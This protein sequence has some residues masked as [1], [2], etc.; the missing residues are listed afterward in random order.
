[1]DF[2]AHRPW[3]LPARPW[4]MA[5]RWHDLLFAHWPVDPERLRP[6][7]PEGLTLD[8]R[9]EWDDPQTWQCKVQKITA[10]V[11][12]AFAE[13]PAGRRHPSRSN[14]RELGIVEDDRTSSTSA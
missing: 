4:I 3:P 8:C 14:L 6:M 13:G 12:A 2:R 7:I 1:M 9:D 5:Q 11:L 10:N